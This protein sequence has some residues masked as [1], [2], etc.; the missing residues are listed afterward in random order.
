MKS[1]H[2]LSHRDLPSKNNQIQ[3]GVQVRDPAVCCARTQVAAFDLPK[4]GPECARIAESEGLIV[5]AIGD[6]IAFCPPLII[7]EAEVQELLLRFRKTLDRL[8]SFELDS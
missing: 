6:T 2:R 3:G 5:R 7:S 1:D 4:Y 8:K